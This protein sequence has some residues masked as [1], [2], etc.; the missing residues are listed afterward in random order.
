M[1]RQNIEHYE[2]ATSLDTLISLRSAAAP[3][4]AFL[5]CSRASTFVYVRARFPQGESCSVFTTGSWRRPPRCLSL[6]G[7]CFL[8]SCER[9]GE[10]NEDN[11][12]CNR[13]VCG[14]SSGGSILPLVGFL[15][16]VC[17]GERWCE[18]RQRV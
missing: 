9:L 1:G 4:V 6:P 11:P 16:L 8:P 17:C 7:S 18:T 12:I 2:I 10:Y 15:V 14:A 5:L 13:S 3:A